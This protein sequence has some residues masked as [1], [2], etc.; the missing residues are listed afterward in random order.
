M[1]MAAPENQDSPTRAPTLR[2]DWGLQSRGASGK[3]RAAPNPPTRFPPTLDPLVRSLLAFLLPHR[4]RPQLAEARR[5]LVAERPPRLGLVEKLDS[6]LDSP[7]WEVRN[8]AVK[9]IAH[10]RE[11]S[12]YLRLLEK[13]TD[14]REAGIVRRNA[15][16]GIAR[17]GIDTDAA[18]TALRRALDDPYWEARAEAAR[19]LAA[20]FPPDPRL[21][22]DL[23]GL[24]YA[25]HRNGR[26]A[27]AE[28]NF[29][30]RMAIAQ[31]LGHLGVSPAAFDALLELAHDD[32][33]P[34]RSQAAVALAHFAT[35]HPELFDR[36]R[37]SLL[38]VDRQSDGAVSY[39]VHRD[40][41]SQALRA[42][43]K[44]PRA[45]DPDA[46]RSIYLNPRAGWNHVRR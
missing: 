43:H 32:A 30:V 20:L 34:V 37:R 2:R 38:E 36:A 5:L 7:A 9:L 19:A 15:A 16:E 35:R 11:H 26:R 6:W 12:R 29:E 8:A 13:L 46:F 4:W 45:A 14:R 33:W 22:H 25:H 21:E 28:D 27:I 23:L 40:V 17:A 3:M 1:P 41:L 39:F 24:L 31:G 44:G 42:I 18:R 10:A